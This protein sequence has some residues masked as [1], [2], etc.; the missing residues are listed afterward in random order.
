MAQEVKFFGVINDKYL[1]PR[2]SDRTIV[3]TV[4]ACKSRGYKPHV[5]L[6]GQQRLQRNRRTLTTVVRT[7]P[8]IELR[9]PIGRPAFY[10]RLAQ[11]LEGHLG[12][13]EG[14]L[15]IVERSS[16]TY[17]KTTLFSQLNLFD[18]PWLI[19]KAFSEE[20][21]G[22]ESLRA[23]RE[24]EG[25]K[26]FGEA[27]GVAAPKIQ[28]FFAV[29]GPRLPQH[30]LVVAETILPG[31]PLL[32]YLELAAGRRA[33][34]RVDMLKKVQHA[35]AQAARMLACVHTVV[36]GQ[37]HIDVDNIYMEAGFL[38]AL[39]RDSGFLD[40]PQYSKVMAAM[41]RLRVRVSQSG[42]VLAH[43]D[44]TSNNLLYHWEDDEVGIID[45][46]KSEQEYPGKDLA[47][48]AETIFIDGTLVG[49]TA[50]E[51]EAVQQAFIRTYFEWSG[52][53]SAEFWAQLRFYQI[54]TSLSLAR[55]QS[56]IGEKERVL[57]LRD[58]VLS[59]C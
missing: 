39:L 14:S 58:R 52:I 13:P 5:G 4:R 17:R 8:V 20:Q 23:F 57:M 24:S 46:E 32:N 33:K 11:A 3:G 30:N 51:I 25:S 18:T 34:K 21:L 44:Y 37:I 12:M 7:L 59:L 15:S 50:P 29:A 38:A 31:M 48:F 41:A 22:H 26:S 47:K 45:L 36:K 43:R 16:R 56:K 2:I 9:S 53:R 54:Y 40:E 1:M 55:Y 6:Q 49:L 19:L 35:F 42:I 10:L 28:A 27:P